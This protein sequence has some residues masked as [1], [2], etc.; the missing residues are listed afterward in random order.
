MNQ[1]LSELW[2]LAYYGYLA[3][4]DYY[5]GKN[6]EQL[7]DLLL[8]WWTRAARQDL[9]IEYNALKLRIEARKRLPK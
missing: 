8:Y 5:K 7:E 3:E 4:R 2:E 6:I 1:K 9:Q